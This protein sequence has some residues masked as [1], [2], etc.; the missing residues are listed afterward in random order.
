MRYEYHVSIDILLVTF[1]LGAV[2]FIFDTI[3]IYPID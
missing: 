3:F 2:Y 1:C